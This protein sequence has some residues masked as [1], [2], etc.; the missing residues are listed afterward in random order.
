MANSFEKRVTES[1]YE[2][3]GRKF[4]LGSYDPIEGNY[5]LSQVVSFVL[6]FG[7]GDALFSSLEEEG[8]EVKINKPARQTN[9]PRMSKEDFTSLM[10]DILMT[11]TEVYEGGSESPVVRDNGTYGVDDVSM[12]LITK[13]VIASLAFNFKSF[14]KDVPLAKDFIQM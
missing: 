12:S 2:D 6:P 4:K 1:I 14:F 5:I 10:R 9:M 8:S 13:L 7:I 3:G 11:V